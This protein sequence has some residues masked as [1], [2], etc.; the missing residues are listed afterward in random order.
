MIS[1]CRRMNL[2]MKVSL[3]FL[4]FLLEEFEMFDVNREGTISAPVRPSVACIMYHQF[5]FSEHS[6]NNQGT[7]RESS[8]NNK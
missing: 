8:V 7:F 6:G 5:S 4:E 1:F 2:R 3:V